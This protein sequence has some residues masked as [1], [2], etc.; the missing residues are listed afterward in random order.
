VSSTRRSDLVLLRRWT[1]TRL[2]LLLRSRR[3]ALLTFVFPLIFLVVFD[4]ING[5]SRVTG[6]GGKVDFVQFFTPGI[7]IWG[8]AISCYTGVAFG[9]ATAR[10]QGILKRVR[11][12]PLPPWI[13]LAA[14]MLAAVVAG[15]AS[16]V[17]MFVVAVP[18]FG[19]H[20]YPRMLPAAIVTLLVG[21]C[22]FAA[23]GL[24][25][26][27]FIRRAE[28]API[29][30]NLT[31]LPL[32]FIS[33]IWYPL[34]GAPHWLQTLAHVFPLSHLAQA[35]EACFSPHTPGAGFH[36]WDLLVLAA[37][38][39]AGLRVAVSRFRRDTDETQGAGGGRVLAG[40]FRA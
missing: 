27:V 22:A 13:Y 35:F 36:A 25:V 30:S 3:T 1:V 14:M 31:L 19:V 28:S 2:R 21:G 12:T 18:G 23:L 37:W 7:G 34:E 10:D 24:A 32:T 5:S 11:G 33:G 26:G 29:V 9:L 20:V 15:L 4:G 16:V 38:G 40:L 6:A 8:L 39:A 17:L